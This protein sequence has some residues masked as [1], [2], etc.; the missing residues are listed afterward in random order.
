MP[1]S[2]VAPAEKKKKAKKTDESIWLAKAGDQ[3]K[4]KNKKP[5][6]HIE[7][8]LSEPLLSSDTIPSMGGYLAYWETVHTPLFPGLKE[9]SQIV[10][11]YMRSPNVNL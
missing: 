2:N 11:K 8:Y 7:S 3:S 1:K 9:A 6:D 4:P 5:H 10:N